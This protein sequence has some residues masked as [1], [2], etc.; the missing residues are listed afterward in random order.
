M[1]CISSSLILGLLLIMSFSVNAQPK[2]DDNK[3]VVAEADNQKDQVIEISN[4]P[5]APEANERKLKKFDADSFPSLLF[6]YWEQVAIEDARRSRGLNRAP[7]EAELMRD[8]QQ[9]DQAEKVKPP[10]EKRYI[11][12][13]G[14]SFK[15]K[16]NW[17][18]WL[19]GQRVTPDAIPPEALDL[20]VFGE[21]I[22]IKWYDDYTNRIIPIRLRP[23]QRFNIDT[24]IFLPG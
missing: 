22:E 19:N 8:L 16:K 17:T 14:I 23:H 13:S 10:P 24:R 11:T 1:F 15:A 5:Q 7:T 9:D 4:D 3:K 12:L 2:M 18:I 6:T 21:Y 20:K